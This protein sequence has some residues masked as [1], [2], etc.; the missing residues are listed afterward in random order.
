MV[1]MALESNNSSYKTSNCLIYLN[2]NND[3]VSVFKKKFKKISYLNYIYLSTWKEYTNNDIKDFSKSSL[4]LLDRFIINY[5]KNYKIKDYKSYNKIF[6]K[7]FST[8]VSMISRRT[9]REVI[10][11]PLEL[12][13]HFNIHYKFIEKYLTFNSIKWLIMSPS[14]SGGFDLLLGVIPQYL[15]IKTIYLENFHS[16]KFFYTKDWRDWGYFKKSKELFDKKRVYIY[17]KDPTEL[18]Y[19]NQYAKSYS[20]SLA[21]K[22]R[23]LFIYEIF[24]LLIKTF[25]LSFFSKKILI[26]SFFETSSKLYM[27][28]TR[29]KFKINSILVLNKNFNNLNIKYVYFAMSFQPEATTLSYGDE[30][31]DQILAIEKIDK[32]IPSDWSILVK[33]HPFHSDPFYRGNL[34]YERLKLIKSVTIIPT[35]KFSN[36]DLIK[37][38]QFVSTVTGNTGWE[39][40]RLLKPVLVFGRPWYL[41][42][43]GVKNIDQLDNLGDFIKMKWSLKDI[44]D[45]IEKLSLKM[46]DGLINRD[47]LNAKDIFN[48][49][50]IT[51]YNKDKNIDNI[52]RSVCKIMENY[53]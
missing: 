37:N 51:K 42:C 39:S 9:S 50:K 36:D 43:P 38:S 3:D 5:T 53:E 6:E 44:K 24:I 16:H 8:Y 34:F 33:E 21:F 17:E 35:T 19:L 45:H 41:T 48:D 22:Y 30:Y 4:V 52:F 1:F 32:I 47:Y 2:L 25:I 15:D 40:I 7:Y 12:K 18:F 20:G 13:H 49:F 27:K 23:F 29:E 31:D 14:Y 10:S 28:A 26:K 46:G 11:N